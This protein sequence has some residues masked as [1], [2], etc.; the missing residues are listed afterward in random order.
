MKKIVGVYRNP[1]MHWVGDGFPVKGLFSYSR[2]NQAISPF[3][4][5]DYGT[6]SL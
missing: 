5:L 2:F 3:L 1:H 4:L 6:L